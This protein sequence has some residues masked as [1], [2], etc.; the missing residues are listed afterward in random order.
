MIAYNRY[1]IIRPALGLGSGK[2]RENYV[3]VGSAGIFDLVSVPLSGSG[4]ELYEI[5]LLW[6][7]NSQGRTRGQTNRNKQYGWKDYDKPQRA[8]DA[9]VN[10][11]PDWKVLEEIEFNWPSLI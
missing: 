9:S 11:G 1:L 3:S 2:F 8:R 7:Y 6:P 10:V 4:L 5:Q